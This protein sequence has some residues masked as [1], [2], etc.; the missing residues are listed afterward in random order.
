VARSM[1][2]IRGK[3]SVSD[4]GDDQQSSYVQLIAV[5]SGSL[6]AWS[7]TR[8]LDLKSSKVAAQCPCGPSTAHNESQFGFAQVP[9]TPFFRPNNFRFE[10][11]LRAAATRSSN[12][13]S[14]MLTA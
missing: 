9:V 13:I 2:V 14:S 4:P 12:A 5:V 10:I 11:E 8:Q 1:K 7:A 6:P 3:Q